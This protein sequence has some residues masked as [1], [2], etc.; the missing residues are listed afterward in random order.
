[1]HEPKPNRTVATLPFT[2]VSSRRHGG[3]TR[4]VFGAADHNLR[5]EMSLMVDIDEH[6]RQLS[7]TDLTCLVG[8]GW[9][10][11]FRLP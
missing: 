6:W 5:L 2:E 3:K 10:L 7:T 9:S 11:D 1:M 4:L 8:Y